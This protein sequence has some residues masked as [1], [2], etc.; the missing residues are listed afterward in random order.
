MEEPD[1]IHDSQYA[2][3]NS[4]AK[5]IL[6]YPKASNYHFLHTSYVWAQNHALMTVF[7]NSI[8]FMAELLETPQV[9]T[10]VHLLSTTTTIIIIIKCLN[11]I[12]CCLNI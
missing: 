6:V 3:W 12:I 7:S 11:F 4:N 10:V 5:R 1:G 2:S 9:I 8:C